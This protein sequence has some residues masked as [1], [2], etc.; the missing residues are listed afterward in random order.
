MSYFPKPGSIGSSV[1]EGFFSRKWGIFVFQGKRAW[2]TKIQSF[3]INFLSKL[4]KREKC[5]G[6]LTSEW[7]KVWNKWGILRKWVNSESEGILEVREIQQLSELNSATSVKCHYFKA[8]LWKFSGGLRPPSP[9]LG[10]APPDPCFRGLSPRAPNVAPP[11]DP[12]GGCATRRYSSK[13]GAW[14]RFSRRKW[15]IFNFLILRDFSLL[16]S[17]PNVV[18]VYL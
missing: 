7:N 13:N 15:G 5:E 17:K 18:N 8:F 12:T 9:P 11:L 16:E 1:T 3:L 4:K 6:N 2:N 10:A 14:R